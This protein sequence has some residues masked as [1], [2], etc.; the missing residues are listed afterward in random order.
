LNPRIRS[1]V[2]EPGIV[3]PLSSI[4]SSKTKLIEKGEKVHEEF[5]TERYTDMSCS[6]RR[7]IGDGLDEFPASIGTA[8]SIEV[9]SDEI[10]E[11]VAIDLATK[12]EKATSKNVEGVSVTRRRT[13]ANGCSTSPLTSG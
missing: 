12:D 11:I 7:R 10:V 6:G 2:K 8:K 3:K 9:E 13:G 5:V 1:C 4:C